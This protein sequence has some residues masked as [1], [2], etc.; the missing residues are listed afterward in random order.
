MR[1]L[2]LFLL[3]LGHFIGNECKLIMQPADWTGNGIN[4]TPRGPYHKWP[5]PRC[6]CGSE[7]LRTLPWM[8]GT[9]V[10]IECKACGRIWRPQ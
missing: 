9:G 4:S 1:I 2:K 8:L 7:L 5:A 3:R 10:A 6:E